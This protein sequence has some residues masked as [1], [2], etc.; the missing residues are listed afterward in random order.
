MGI[1]VVLALVVI[2]SV[3]FHFLSPGWWTPI[4]SNWSYIDHTLVITFWI[5]GVVFAAVVLLPAVG[6]D[7][8]G[9]FEG[10]D[11]WA[12]GFGAAA[13]MSRPRVEHRLRG[14]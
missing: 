1:A 2:G 9:P 13:R 10:G 3:V 12:V 4:A 11:G 14:R 7:M 8:V 5:T 6:W